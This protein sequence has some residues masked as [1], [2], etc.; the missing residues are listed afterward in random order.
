[1][2]SKAIDSIALSFCHTEVL[3]T[4]FNWFWIVGALEESGKFKLRRVWRE[5][6]ENILIET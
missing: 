4:S 6:R 1:V 5:R 3:F 2:I